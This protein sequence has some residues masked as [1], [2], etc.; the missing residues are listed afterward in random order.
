[1]IIHGAFLKIQRSSVSYK[2]PPS[3]ELYSLFFYIYASFALLLIESCYFKFHCAEQD[4]DNKGFWFWFWFW[5]SENVRASCLWRKSCDCSCRGFRVSVDFPQFGPDLNV[6][7]VIKDNLR[8]ACRIESK[9]STTGSESCLIRRMRKQISDWLRGNRLD[10]WECPFHFT[11]I[12]HGSED[13]TVWQT[14]KVL[15]DG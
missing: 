2:Y 5:T 15:F 4:N 8:L 6:F 3:C 11:L 12:I 13:L 1:M 10:Q 9:R 7:T 14:F